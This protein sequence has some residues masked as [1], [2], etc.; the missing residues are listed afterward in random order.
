[1]QGELRT[2]LTA[3]LLKTGEGSAAPKLAFESPPQ[4]GVEYTVAFRQLVSEIYA[5]GV[6]IRLFLK[7][8]T[9][10][11]SNP[12]FFLEKLVEF[13]ESSFN[14]Q[15]PASS[16][17]DR[18][19]GEDNSDSRAVVLGKEDFLSLLTSCI[20]CV[21]KGE[22]SVHDHLLSWG[23]VHLLC[24]LLKRALDNDRRGTPVTCVVRLLHQLVGRVDTVDNM[25]SSPVDIIVQLTRALNVN[26]NVADHK[27]PELPK[28]AAFSVEL[29]KKIFQ[30]IGSRNLG[31]F[32]AMGMQA[33]LPSYLLDN[34]IG[35]PKQAIEHVRNS[36]A[37]RIHAV[38]VLKAMIAA[39][40]ANAPVLQALLDTHSA[41][42]EFRDQSHDLFITVSAC[43]DSS[44]TRSHSASTS[45]RNYHFQRS[46]SIN[47]IQLTLNLFF[48]F[49]FVGSRTVGPVPNRG[50]VGH[51]IQ[52]PLSSAH[53]W[54][55]PEQ[56]H[57]SIFHLN[58][59]SSQ[60]HHGSVLFGFR[61]FC[62]P[63]R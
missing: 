63:S 23:F 44:H 37:L 24:D 18:F 61:S 8:P 33:R 56:Q 59:N 34:I 41:W 42:S 54:G 21:V 40:E 50:R 4:I 26:S 38:D 29:L 48:S 51:A 60:H 49:L 53:R 32:V 57:F 43:I 36:A 5:G 28:D 46:Q 3:L 1:M 30:C 25:A 52:R 31:H 16:K 6:Y 14:V 9:F 20:V 19:Y 55:C 47:Y 62:R 35:A 13:W 12:V 7:Q 11:L 27:L 10:R 45:V 15:V 17:K 58:D 22:S 39:D 2:A